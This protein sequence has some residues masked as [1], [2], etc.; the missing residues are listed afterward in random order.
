MG[1]ALIMILATGTTALAAQPDGRLTITFLSVGPAG[2]PAQGEAILIHTPDNKTIL[3]DGGLDSTS[4][5]QELDNRLPFWQR[6]LDVLMLTNDR[7]DHLTGLQDIVTRYQVG[8]VLDAGM[9]HPTTGYALWRRTIRE[10][11]LHYVQVRQGTTVTVGARV[12]LQI[13]WPPSPLHQ[14][15]SEEFDNT[16]VIRLLAPGLHLLLLGASA[17]SKFAL[18]GLLSTI[19]PSYL[20][21]DVVQVVGEVGKGFPV[22]LADV[23][24][25]AHPSLL[26]ITP[27][28]LSPKQRKAG[29]TSTVLPASAM[30]LG[31]IPSSWHI[32]QTA[33]LGTLEISRD[34]SLPPSDGSGWSLQPG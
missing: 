27:A 11:N 17:Q 31:T 21:A 5:G 28:S 1:A 13:L 8:E 10:R 2:F 26:L 30:D 33:D 29:V 9:L 22:E 20:Q 25:A 3:I 23:L 34:V 7:T 15:S 4:L 18:S 32:V 14:G 6:S 16:L 24:Q 12:M 19:D